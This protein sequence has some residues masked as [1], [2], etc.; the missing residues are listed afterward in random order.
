MNKNKY[1]N[2][3]KVCGNKL[4]KRGKTANGT[5]RYYCVN[6]NKSNII[7]KDY[8][9]KRNELKMFVNWILDK[10]TKTQSAN[11]NRR[12]FNNK[13]NWCWD[14]TPKIKFEG[15]D[16]K[17]IVVDT[18]Y[19]ARDIGLMVVRNGND[20][21]NYRWCESENYIDYFKLLK[22]LKEPNFLICDGCTPLIKVATKLW[23]SIE[24][25]RCLFHIGLNTKAKL[26][27]RSPYQ[28]V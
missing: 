6:C 10:P 27:Q 8:L 15:I 14:V 28:A 9:T 21:L 1:K 20:V 18:T 4:Q 12:T 24:I 3:C 5:Q 25:Q 22:G 16:S 13:T 17:F 2:Q 26:G 11:I 23:K 7:K 19:L